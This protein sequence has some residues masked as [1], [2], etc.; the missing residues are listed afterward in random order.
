MMTKKGEKVFGKITKSFMGMSRNKRILIIGVSA[1]CLIMIFAGILN[2]S[3]NNLEKASEQLSSAVEGQQQANSAP[4][5]LSA[6][7]TE[8]FDPSAIE[9]A[10]NEPV[11]QES[12]EETIINQQDNPYEVFPQPK[13]EKPRDMIV[14]LKGIKNEISFINS[15][16]K[17]FQH[18]KRVWSKGEKFNDWYIIES[19]NSV[20]IRFYDNA[21]K[22]S[23]NLRF[24][25]E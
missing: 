6:A 10:K 7:N 11:V 4:P 3:K 19:V 1:M 12:V 21:E 8:M 22:Y 17:N 18:N 15:K 16:G 2:K 20:Y 5:P 9:Q 24:I 13:A 23:Y 25:E 14:Y